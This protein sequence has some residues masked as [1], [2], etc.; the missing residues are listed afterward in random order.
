M[1]LST[2][3]PTRA[4]PEPRD[5][6]TTGRR[7]ARWLAVLTVVVVAWLAAFVVPAYVTF[8][9]A[10]ARIGLTDDFPLH[11]PVLIVHIATGMI[12]MVTGCVQL[13][14][15][16]R[17]RY[18]V[19]HRITGRVY[20]YAIL[21]GILSVVVLIV[22]RARET[23]EFLGAA[24]GVGNSV[25]AVLW[26]GTTLAGVRF[27]RQR[28]WAEHRKMMIYSVALTL[29]IMWSRIL[30][31]GALSIPDFNLAYFFAAV[32]W[33]PWISH[34]LIARWWLSRTSTRPLALPASVTPAR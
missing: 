5:R 26:F 23:T 13:S 10:Q 11:Y 15:R 20:A 6:G 7:R 14:A 22:L 18:P 8:D 12:A 29:A 30:F 3:E 31:I 1:T 2:G 21:F 25:W 27:A 32:A 34:L 9:P 4:R 19:A 17:R 16:V 33:L 28:R 24:T